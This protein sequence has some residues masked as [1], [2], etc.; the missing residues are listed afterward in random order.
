V[1]DV[2]GLEFVECTREYPEL[3]AFGLMNMGLYSRIKPI[4]SINHSG[5]LTLEF[6]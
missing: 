5:N 4:S 6:V 1:Y 2:L 3:M